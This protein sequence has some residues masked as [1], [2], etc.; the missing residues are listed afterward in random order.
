MKKY[1]LVLLLCVISVLIIISQ[2][3]SQAAVIMHV[4]YTDLTHE[5][6]KEVDC[7]AENIYKEAGHEPQDGKLAVGLVTLNRVADPRFPEN[8]CGVV[9]Q[10]LKV[11]KIGDTKVVCQFSWFCETH[12]RIDKSSDAYIASLKT[13][14]FVY[15]NYEYL[16]DL[17]KGALYYHADY[18]NPRWR[19]LV[20]TT[21][22]GRHI[23]YKET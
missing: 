14:L 7:L 17:T 8:I 15:A 16:H 21:K 9:K 5:A 3:S 13:A 18:V 2:A 10:K 20:V 12:K 22:I 6:R 19:N 11:S 1:L 23:F 4:N